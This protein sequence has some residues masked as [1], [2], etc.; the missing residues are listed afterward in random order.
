MTRSPETRY[1]GWLRR[2]V[3]TPEGTD[4]MDLFAHLH[5][6]EFVWI[7]PNDD[8]RV[9][10][11]LDLRREFLGEAHQISRHGVSVLEVLVSLSRRLEFQ[12]QGKA[13]RWAWTL[14]E[15]LE[16]HKMRDPVSKRKADR[17]EDILEALIWRTYERDGVGGF[18]PLAWPQED[19]TKVELWYQMSAYI[20]E[21]PDL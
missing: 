12:A 18:F 5:H 3:Y 6:K 16:L 14:L 8:N 1:F 4:Y 20:N 13:A 15:N 11:A 2:Q 19:Q 21:L 7:I 17:I 10:D 9:V